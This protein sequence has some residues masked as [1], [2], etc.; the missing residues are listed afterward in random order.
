MNKSEVTARAKRVAKLLNERILGAHDPIPGDD[1]FGKPVAVTKMTSVVGGGYG[2][3]GVMFKN[4]KVLFFV[5]GLRAEIVGP[6]GGFCPHAL[7]AADVLESLGIISQADN[8]AFDAWYCATSERTSA[9]QDIEQ[10]RREAAER[11]YDLVKRAK[12]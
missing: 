4:G 3:D 6:I 2:P 7:K 11:G 8:E 9:R 12:K 1:G 10:F 5:C